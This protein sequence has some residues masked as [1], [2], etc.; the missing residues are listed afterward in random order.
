M[1]MSIHAWDNE[2]FV[3]T[4]RATGRETLIVAGRW[5]SVCVMFSALDA[6]VAGFKVYVVMDPSGDPSEI[7]RREQRLPVCPGRLLLSE[8]RWR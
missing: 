5:T 8:V 3:K 7:V 1:L 4:V 2:D 6:K